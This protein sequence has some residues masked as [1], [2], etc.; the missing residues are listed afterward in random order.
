MR[1]HANQSDI[2]LVMENAFNLIKAMYIQGVQK[3]SIIGKIVIA[4]K[5]MMIR[6]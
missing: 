4:S 6:E 5:P 1:T 2:K 3:K